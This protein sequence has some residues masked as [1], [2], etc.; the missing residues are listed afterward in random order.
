MTTIKDIAREA[1]VSVT[2]VSR[3]LNGYD[4][5]NEITRKKIIEI[6]HR[7]K[8]VPNRA[9]QNLVKKE[10]NTI[11]LILS[12]FESD[13]GISN[14]VFK[15]LSGMYEQA[16]EYG[17]N[18]ALFTTNTAH[19]RET[20]YFQFC[21][22][23]NICGAVVSGL[24]IDDPYFKELVDS[25]IPCILS[26]VNLT[27]KKVTV[28]TVNNEEASYE[29]VKYLIDKKHKNIAM[30]NGREEAEVSKLRFAGYKKALIEHN[31]EVK[32][33]YIGIGNF[34]EEDTYNE[35]KRILENNKEVTAIF[36]ASDLMAITAMRAIRDMGKRV[37][38][39]ISIAGFDDIVL[40]SHTTPPLTTVKQDF[41]ER[42][43]VAIREIEK[44][45][46]TNNS[47][48][49]VEMPY[50]IVIRESVIEHK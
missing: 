19:Q 3:A 9:A 36:C 49:F 33:S 18:V 7:M 4:D 40:S 12:G 23:N 39:D 1:G 32:E 22:A 44:I 5:V 43:K 34:I 20:S 37:P 47:N 17:Y 31:I 13:D 50:K 26:D 45:L 15:L 28:L 10:N 2:T 21:R 46:K 14:L 24:R 6:A 41:K 11:A 35:T 48:P 29:M 25:N 30:I 8:Y 42:G 38:E 27:G 16:Q